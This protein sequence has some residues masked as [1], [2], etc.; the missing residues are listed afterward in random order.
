MQG[1]TLFTNANVWFMGIKCDVMGK[2][3][4]HNYELGNRGRQLP[5]TRARKQPLNS[6]QL[7]QVKCGHMTRCSRH[8][9]A[10]LM[11]AALKCSDS[12]T[13]M[14]C[15]RRLRCFHLQQIDRS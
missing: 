2:R 15:E 5:I 3:T 8:D 11:L 6:P 14:R 12:Y 10:E 7:V 9:Y 1:K 13:V 4:H